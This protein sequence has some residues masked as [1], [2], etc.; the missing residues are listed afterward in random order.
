[1]KSW[2]EPLDFNYSFKSR[3]TF[4][5]PPQIEAAATAA[6]ETAS[7]GANTG[8][9]GAGG[10]PPYGPRGYYSHGHGLGRYHWRPR[11]GLF[12][13]MVWVSLFRQIGVMC[14]V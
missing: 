14:T 6:A 8:A 12:R 1:M 9:A 5:S 3:F 4:P 10:H 7:A 11:F 2:S 13:R